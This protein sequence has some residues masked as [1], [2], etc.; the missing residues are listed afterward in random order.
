MNKQE[1]NPEATTINMLAG[2]LPVFKFI[3]I[4]VIIPLCISFLFLHNNF[5]QAQCLKTTSIYY[6]TVLLGPKSRWAQV[7]MVDR[8]ETRQYPDRQIRDL[9]ENSGGRGVSQFTSSL[10]TIH[11]QVLTYPASKY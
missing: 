9:S 7:G 3:S 5:L 6:F 8:K 1:N 10:R 4:K 11:F 2:F